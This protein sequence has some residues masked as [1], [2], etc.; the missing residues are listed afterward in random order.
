MW[1]DPKRT[2]SLCQQNP[3]K[4]SSLPKK[5]LAYPYKTL[6]K[7]Q[8]YPNKT[9]EIPEK[10]LSLWQQNFNDTLTLSEQNPKKTQ[11]IY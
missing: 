2:L 4:T 1:E 6:R 8:A 7:L 11:N 10:I 3:K 5:L 9:Q